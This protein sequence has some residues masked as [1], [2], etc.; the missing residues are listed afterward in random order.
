MSEEVKVPVS[1]RN[2]GGMWGSKA[3]AYF[4]SD[5]EKCVV[6]GSTPNKRGAVSSGYLHYLSFKDNQAKLQVGPV[7]DGPGNV[8]I[9]D[10]PPDIAEGAIQAAIGYVLAWHGLPKA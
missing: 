1:N 4:D 9:H 2:I 10:I 6:L 7:M 8:T 5:R 3:C